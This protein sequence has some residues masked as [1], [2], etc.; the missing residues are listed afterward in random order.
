MKK[1]GQRRRYPLTPSR[2][3]YLGGV[4]CIVDRRGHELADLTDLDTAR[5]PVARPESALPVPCSVL[6]TTNLEG[7]AEGVSR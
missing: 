2:Y 7:P 4:N 6:G 1:M 5:T 3:T